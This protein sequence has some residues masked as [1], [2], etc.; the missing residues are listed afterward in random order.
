MC[1]FIRSCSVLGMY[2]SSVNPLQGEQPQKQHLSR[3]GYGTKQVHGGNV[4]LFCSV[5]PS[6]VWCGNG[7][8][9]CGELRRGSIS[10]W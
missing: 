7:Q 3:V 4:N 8:V 10:W 2:I 9:E 6:V 1:Y 5:G